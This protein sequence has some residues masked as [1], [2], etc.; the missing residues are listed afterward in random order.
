MNQQKVHT[1]GLKGV[2]CAKKLVLFLQE[3]ERHFC[4]LLYILRGVI[5]DGLN[6]MIEVASMYNERVYNM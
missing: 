4:F 5:L 6:T 1:V 2:T 3:V